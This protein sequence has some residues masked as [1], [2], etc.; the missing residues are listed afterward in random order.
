MEDA[1]DEWLQDSRDQ[2]LSTLFEDEIGGVDLNP[3]LMLPESSPISDAI[4]LM[5]KFKMGCILLGSNKIPIGI[6]TERDVLNKVLPNGVNINTTPVSEFMTRNPQC[7]RAHHQVAHA[8]NLM[9][10]G[11]YRHVPIVNGK[12]EAQGVFSMRSFVSFM[13]DLF[14]NEILNVAPPNNREHAEAPE[15]A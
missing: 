4:H 11:G 7:L 9:V 6:F 5:N 12:G 13:V 8:L 2:I 3:P 10:D 14:P 1:Y 15:G